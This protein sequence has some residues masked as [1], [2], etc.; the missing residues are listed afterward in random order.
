[1]D[2]EFLIAFNKRFQQFLKAYAQL[3]KSQHYIKSVPELN[4][5]EIHTLVSIADNQPLNLVTLSQLRGISRSAVTQMTAKLESKGFLL[6]I[7][8]KDNRQEILLSL[9]PS[10]EE[11]Y[12]LHQKQHDYL[13]EKILTVLQTY[14]E[15]LLTDLDHLMSDLEM[16]WQDLP[17]RS[18]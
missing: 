11:I 4:L 9:T 12:K 15:A 18:R 14:P 13:E 16:I 1:M 3:E 6:K 10:G 7:P 5:S 2:K 8:N 17:W